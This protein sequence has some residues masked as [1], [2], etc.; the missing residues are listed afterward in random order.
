MIMKLLKRIAVFSFLSVCVLSLSVNKTYASPVT[1][2]QTGSVVT[3]TN[4]MLTITY[5][6]SIGKG[7]CSAGSTSI[8]SNFYSDYGVSGSSTRISSYDS[9]TRTASWVSI[10]TD[11]YGS[12]GKKLT[13][14]NSLTSG[15]TIILNLTLYSDKP[16]ALA[17]M[18]VNKGTSQTLNFLEAIAAQNLDIGT[19]SDKRIY[20]TPYN[21]NYDF[22]V[23]PVNDFG[24]SENQVDRTSTTTTTWSAFDGTSFW[25][26]AMFD[27]TNKQGFIAGAATTVNWKPYQY[28]QRT[29]RSRQLLAEAKRW[30]EKR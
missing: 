15:S 29:A 1:I 24:N 3:A 5:D 10:G 2:S 28:L 21:N 23:A 4:G 25:V 30:H 20:T 13:I 19:G 18:T 12:S 7:N 14:T 22:G 6:L 9:G 26:A 17:S 27:N 8:I 16:F 11:G